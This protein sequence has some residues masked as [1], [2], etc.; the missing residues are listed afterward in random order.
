MD[1]GGKRMTRTQIKRKLDKINERLEYYYEKEKALL[2]N[3]GVQSYTIGSRTVS[4]YQYSS[5]IKEQIE[6]LERQRDE[7]ESRLA[8]IKPRKAV[9]VV[10]RDW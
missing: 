4:R 10:L 3:D 5:D 9:G 1:V 8:G 6:N 7:L 2:T